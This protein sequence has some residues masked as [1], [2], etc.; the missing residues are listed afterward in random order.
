MDS[1][2]FLW[3]CLAVLVFVVVALAGL[4]YVTVR[5]NVAKDQM[6]AALRGTNADLQHAITELSREQDD[7]LLH[8]GV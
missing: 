7:A 2:G 1:F 3:L 6:I 5:D 8:M 4:L